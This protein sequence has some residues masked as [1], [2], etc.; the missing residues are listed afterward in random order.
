MLRVTRSSV[1]GRALREQSRHFAGQRGRVRVVDP[2][3]VAF[4]APV[5]AFSPWRGWK[6]HA[7]VGGRP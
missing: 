7:P 2:L 4:L 1:L 3:Q 5:R 6:Q